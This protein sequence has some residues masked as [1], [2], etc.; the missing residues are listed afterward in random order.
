MKDLQGKG[1]FITGGA[2][3]IGLAMGRAMLEAGMKVVLA[4]IERR[5][6]DEA[7]KSLGNVG[8]VRGALCDV[9]DRAAMRRAADEAFAALGKVHVL[10]NN[11]GVA[12]G[13]PQDQVTD[14][15]WDWILG[16][17]LE[18]VASGISAFLP[19]I[20]AQGEG[21]HVVNTAS[22][23][24]MLS[25]AFMGPYAATKFAVV[26]LS[27]GLAAELQ[28]SNIGVTAL[29]PGWVKTKINES[30]RNR[31]DRFGGKSESSL[32]GADAVMKQTVNE[33]IKTGL[34][35]ADVAE[36]VLEAIRENQLYVFTH[37]A[38]RSAVED[39]F[40]RIQAAFDY[41]ETRAKR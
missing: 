16:V 26:A 12:L 14:R 29:C 23:A 17:N 7:V 34:E 24:G 20:K 38:M 19:R 5:A 33:A 6:L 41:A 35:P 2:S 15:D 4:D 11:A 36:R 28:G 22:M 31:P 37:P 8:D 30:G 32:T 18:A 21:G 1:A 3:G 10:C 25:P 40:K 9:S 13:G 27:E 39:R